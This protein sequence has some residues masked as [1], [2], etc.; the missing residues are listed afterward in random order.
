MYR[1]F[2]IE[3][4]ETIA[5]EIKRHLEGWGY[6]AA[7]ARDFQNVQAEIEA[8][9][10]HLILL[11]VF[12]PGVSGFHVCEEVR[13]RS[14]APVI[15]ISSAS[16]NMNIV[17]AMSMGGDDFIAKP[18]DLRVLSAKVQAMLRRSYDFS[19]DAGYL[20]CGG[21]RLCP[22]D[23]S[24]MCGGARLELT[25]NEYRILQ[26]LLEGRGKIISRDA[27]MERLWATDSYIDENTLSVNVARLRKKL[28][29]VGLCDFITTKKG[30]GY[31]IE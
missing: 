31:L 27:L 16:D 8:F 15:F 11:D 4:D 29:A 22:A 12:L 30:L 13:K 20:E 2:I 6:S 19:N 9:A 28:D 3:D 23:A 10:P 21:V 18:F 5:A 17:M 1:I 24:V 7:C 26:T 14:K 25:K